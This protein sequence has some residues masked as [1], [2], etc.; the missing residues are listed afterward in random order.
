[1][2]VA[3]GLTWLLIRAGTRLGV[4]LS[5]N[6]NAGRSRTVLEGSPSIIGEP[7]GTGMLEAD[8]IIFYD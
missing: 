4:T 5:M 6:M 3:E 7:S 1:M 2:F 8:S